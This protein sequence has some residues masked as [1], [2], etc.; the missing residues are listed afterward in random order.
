MRLLGAPSNV[1]RL[2][3]GR[4][5]GQVEELQAIAERHVILSH[6]APSLLQKVERTRLTA[7]TRRAP[8]RTGSAE[9]CSAMFV[10]SAA[11]LLVPLEPRRFEC[12]TPFRVVIDPHGDPILDREDVVHAVL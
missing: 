11:E 5:A 3:D 8:Q 7:A 2:R 4:A 1:G 9:K 12:R 6:A 10:L